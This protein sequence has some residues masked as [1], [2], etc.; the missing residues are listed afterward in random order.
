MSQALTYI[1]VGM[2]LG[3]AICAMACWYVL[4]ET[5]EPR[6]AHQID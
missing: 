4:R 6:Q 5:D 3:I 1:A 2:A